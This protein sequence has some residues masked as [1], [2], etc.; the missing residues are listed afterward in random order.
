MTLDLAQDGGR[1]KRG[2]LESA[3]RVKAVDCL[4]Q[5]QIA[6]LHQ[7]V[8]RLAAILKFVGKEPY[9]VHMGHDELL[10]SIRITGLLITTKQLAGFLLVPSGLAAPGAFGHIRYP[11]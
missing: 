5:A 4:E 10:A 2:E 9:Q 3:L 6:N 1:G 8:E 7:V 11:P